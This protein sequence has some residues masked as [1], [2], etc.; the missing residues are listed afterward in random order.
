[1][2]LVF[3][4]CSTKEIDEDF[5]RFS[6]EQSIVASSQVNELCT[7]FLEDILCDSLDLEY[8]MGED[9]S[10]GRNSFGLWETVINCNG[11]PVACERACEP[12]EVI[13]GLETGIQILFNE[14]EVCQ[15]GVFSVLEQVG[16]LNSIL[17]YAEN[18]A[19]LCNGVPMTPAY[20]DLL[21]YFNPATSQV[22]FGAEVLYVAPC[23]DAIG[24]GGF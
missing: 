13:V 10:K 6:E 22:Y 3:L 24:T 12:I 18:N 19:P 20:F 14:L 21:W 9:A 5:S 1:M 7:S 16:Y 11:Y 8:L 23:I 15:D 2:S 17:Q 4:Q